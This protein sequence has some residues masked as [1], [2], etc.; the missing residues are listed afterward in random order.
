MRIL[1]V[2]V[3]NKIA[4]YTARD[5]HI[6]CGNSD[7]S[8]KFTF[9][10]EWSKH[11]TKTARFVYNGKY[12]DQEFTGN[13]CVVPVITGADR[14]EVGVFAGSLTTT[15]PASIPCERSILCL[16]SEVQNEQVPIYKDEVE[17]SASQAMAAANDLLRAILKAKAPTFTGWCF[18]LSKHLQKIKYHEC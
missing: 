2:V 13:E 11:T 7:Y 6:V 18:L 9:D 16:T 10:S 17:L 12:I 3:N 14:V 8:L 1:H 5:G 4:T 15:T